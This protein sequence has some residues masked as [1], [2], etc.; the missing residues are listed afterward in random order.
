MKKLIL[1]GVLTCSA[2]FSRRAAADLGTPAMPAVLRCY[3]DG[4]RHNPRLGGRVVISWTIIRD[5]AVRNARIVSSTLPDRWVASCVLGA[6]ADSV[7][8]HAGMFATEVS[9]PFVFTPSR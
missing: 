6:V 9:Y 4:L 3:E 7:F 2:L 8:P 5:G 1:A